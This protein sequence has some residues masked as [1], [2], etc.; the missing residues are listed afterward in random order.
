M[1]ASSLIGILVGFKR[2]VQNVVWSNH[3]IKYYF[4]ILKS[5]R[6]GHAG[7]KHTA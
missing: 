6:V 2:D 5:L 3:E 4:T 1:S 7:V